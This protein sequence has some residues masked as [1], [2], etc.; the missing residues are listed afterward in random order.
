MG[1]PGGV[2]GLGLVPCHHPG[3]LGLLWPSR[4]LPGQGEGWVP[5]AGG[6][7][8]PGR[9]RLQKSRA[10][11]CCA[12]AK[13]LWLNPLPPSQLLIQLFRASLYRDLIS[14]VR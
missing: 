13:R 12:G 11:K 3:C 9:A 7:T 14:P 4:R 10:L 5:G 1:L 2:R 8:L 6:W